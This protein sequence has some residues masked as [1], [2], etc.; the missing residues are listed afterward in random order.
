[1]ILLIENK[2]LAQFKFYLKIINLKKKL[3]FFLNYFVK[4]KTKKNKTP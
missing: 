3:N 2:D 1:M 4:I